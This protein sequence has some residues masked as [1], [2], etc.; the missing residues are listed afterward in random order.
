MRYRRLG[1]VLGLTA[2]LLAACGGEA[3]EQQAAP[4]SADFLD[5]DA[6]VPPLEMPDYP[7]QQRGR[8]VGRAAGPYEIDGAWEARAGICEDPPMLQVVAQ[9]PGTGTLVLLQL[10]PE[11]ERVTSYPVALIETGFPEAPA[12]QIGVQLF[13]GRNSYAF[14]AMEGDVEVYAFGERVSGRYAVSL[15][16]IGSG[17]TA[18]YAGVFHAVPIEPIPEEQC[19][20]AK[21]A[22][23]QAAPAAEPDTAGGGG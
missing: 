11:G 9:E 1:V 17:D 3:E 2:G 15:R 19:L 5:E 7:V 18:L 21:E 13:V 16:E 22:A 8:L 6:P 14:Q 23:Q 12:S 4:E 10:P 20:A